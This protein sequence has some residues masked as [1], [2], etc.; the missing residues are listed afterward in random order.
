MEIGQVLHDQEHDLSIDIEPQ[1][2][3]SCSP[4]SPISGLQDD[5]PSKDSNGPAFATETPNT[6]HNI[7]SSFGKTTPGVGMGKAQMGR[8][9]KIIATANGRCL[10]TTSACSPRG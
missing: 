10:R 4:M 7:Q 6:E 2:F 9:V 1:S 5:V 8:N 3:P